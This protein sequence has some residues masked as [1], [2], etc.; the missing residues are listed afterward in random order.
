M[1]KIAKEK[2]IN[3]KEA[4]SIAKKTYKGSGKILIY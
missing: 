2:E 3:F 1:K 4:L